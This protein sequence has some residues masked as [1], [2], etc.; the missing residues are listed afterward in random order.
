MKYWPP[1]EENT[2]YPWQNRRNNHQKNRKPSIRNQIRVLRM[3]ISANTDNA[4]RVEQIGAKIRLELE[5]EQ[6]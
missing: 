3:Q 5:L 4:S 6:L 1:L 2:Q